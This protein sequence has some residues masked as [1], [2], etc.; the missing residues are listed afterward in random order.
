MNTS[1]IIVCKD[2]E[3]SFT[4]EELMQAWINVPVC[5]SC[6]CA[7]SDYDL[8]TKI[9]KLYWNMKP[10]VRYGNIIN[11]LKQTPKKT[12][13]HHYKNPHRCMYCNKKYPCKC[14]N[15]Y[16]EIMDG[17]ACS[18]RHTPPLTGDDLTLEAIYELCAP[19]S[20]NFI[21]TSFEVNCANCPSMYGYSDER[22]FFSG[23]ALLRTYKALLDYATIIRDDM[24]RLDFAKLNTLITAFRAEMIGYQLTLNYRRSK[25]DKKEHQRHG[26][27]AA[28][29]FNMPSLYHVTDT[30]KPT[31]TYRP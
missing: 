5:P 12:S 31:A 30:F 15:Q 27:Q 21:D 19:T 7:I 25:A 14:D 26:N 28:K 9:P 13:S 8:D 17:T 24:D 2:C 20:S 18:F 6:C 22:V 3:T 4:P 11:F 23:Y 16:A 10:W 1:N 29:I